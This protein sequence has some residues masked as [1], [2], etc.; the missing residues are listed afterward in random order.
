[1]ESKTIITKEQIINASREVFRRLG[2][3]AVTMADIAEAAGMGRSS[4]YYYFKNKDEVLYAVFTVESSEILDKAKNKIK[5]TKSFYDNFLAFDR[6]R[7]SLLGKLTHEFKILLND[8]RKNPIILYAIKNINFNK[9][10]DIYR[11][12]LSWGLLRNDIAPV[13]IEDLHFLITNMIHALKGLEQEI[14]LFGKMEELTSRLEWV[15]SIISK[16]LK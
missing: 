11:Q 1:M 15:A 10:F 8:I 3:S 2:Y 7:L 4:L 14:I 12:M 9:E 6:E 5:S 16:G 13:T